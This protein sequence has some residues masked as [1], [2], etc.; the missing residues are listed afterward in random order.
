MK[1]TRKFF[2]FIKAINILVVLMMMTSQLAGVVRP[3]FASDDPHFNV[4]RNTN[5]LHLYGWRLGATLTVSFNDPTN[6]PGDDFQITPIPVSEFGFNVYFD[7]EFDIDAGDIITVTDGTTSLMH[8]VKNLEILSAAPDTNIVTGIAE[9]G[10]PVW[11]GSNDIN[12]PLTGQIVNPDSNGNWEVDFS[13]DDLQPD[14]NIVAMQSDEQG[15][16]TQWDF[17]VYDP[18]RIHVNID[19]Y[20]V[21]TFGWTTDALLTMTINASDVT[22]FDQST[23]GYFDLP[24]TLN[25]K[26]GDVITITDGITTKKYT[27]APVQVT[28]IDVDA[29]TIS[30]F[31]TPLSNLE[32]HTDTTITGGG[33]CTQRLVTADASGY[34][35]ADFHDPLAP[36]P[37]ESKYPTANLV[38]GSPGQAIE[39]DDEGNETWIDWNVPNPIIEVNMTGKWIQTQEYVFPPVQ[40]K[41][42]LDTPLTLTVDDPSNGDGIDYTGVAVVDHKSNNQGRSIQ[43][44]ANFAW[45]DIGLQPG[46]IVTVT[47]NGISKT[48]VISPLKVDTIDVQSDTIIGLANPGATIQVCINI[49][50]DCIRRY[51]TANHYSSN[52][53]AD[54]HNPG[55]L[56]DEQQIVDITSGTSG[57]AVESD[58]DGD[59]T[60]VDWQVPNPRFNAVLDEN[61]IYGFEWPDSALITL[62][63]DDPVTIQ[64]PDFIETKTSIVASEDLNQAVVSFDPVNL[65]LRPG[66]VVTMTD[67]ISIKNHTIIRI[68]WNEINYITDVISGIAEPKMEIYLWVFDDTEGTLRHFLPN[69]DGSWTTSFAIQGDEPYE[70]ILDL[71]EGM[72]GGTTQ[73]DSD[74]DQTQINWVDIHMALNQSPLANA[75][76]NK[77]VLA[78]DTITLDAS[79]SS[80][81]DGDALTYAW[82]I[83]DDG[84][85]D[86][87]NGLTVNTSFIQPGDHVIGL[88][89]TDDGGLSDTDTIVLTVLPWTLTGFYQPV[90]MNGIYNLVKGGSTVPLKFEIFAGSAELTDIFDVKNLTYAET[91]CDKNAATDEIEVTT[92]GSTSLRYDTQSGQFIYNWKTPSTAGKCYRVTMMTMDG[93]SLV[94]YFKIK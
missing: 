30:G 85:Y 9:P 71:H 93:S 37:P 5:F 91:A 1:T 86:D 44:Q 88:Q 56:P 78:G 84:E 38:P 72:G 33:C 17:H 43:T 32:V 36:A 54:Y 16:N 62:T 22:Y 13:A 24:Q 19:D 52:W 68:S 25:L 92:I 61:M 58:E 45:P 39:M 50:N 60:L 27:I 53:L 23:V 6:G 49:P 70:T 77:I 55:T 67:G 28:N 73:I 51:V 81:P 48:L 66:M 57:R 69:V 82:D 79:A 83:D 87:V 3:V 63:I 11:V 12:S 94:A 59:Q 10:T 65:T 75:G 40:A 42:P 35:I 31:A 18:P 7:G 89:V 74:G 14:Y 47:G 64:D 41:W 29:D 26:S 4:G 2:V 76:S 90:D 46:F 20:W 80:D 8:T 21:Q 34:W 15:N